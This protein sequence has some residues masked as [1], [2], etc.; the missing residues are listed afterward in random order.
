VRADRHAAFGHEPD[1]SPWRPAR[2]LS[3]HA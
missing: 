3:E 1:Q 2:Q